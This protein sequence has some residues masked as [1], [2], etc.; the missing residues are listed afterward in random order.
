MPYQQKITLDFQP[1]IQHKLE[2]QPMAHLVIT[3]AY[4]Q[5]KKGVL[6][7][8]EEEAV[9]YFELRDTEFQQQFPTLRTDNKLFQKKL[10]RLIT[11]GLLMPHHNCACIGNYYAFTPLAKN[12]FNDYTNI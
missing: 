4:E 5:A 9:L 3:W 12:I 8:I 7:C 1:L 6:P 10:T 2:L 11:K